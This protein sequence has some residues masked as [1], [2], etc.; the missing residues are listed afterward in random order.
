M[1]IC[2]YLYVVKQY[3]LI[4]VKLETACK[5][6]TFPKGECSMKCS[7]IYVSYQFKN[8]DVIFKGGRLVVLVHDDSLD[9]GLSRRHELRGPRNVELAELHDQR[10]QEA[11]IVLAKI[12]LNN[13]HPDIILI[14]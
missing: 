3:G 6:D 10:R 5:S 13:H 14:I 9:L 4:F 8:G 11:G 1:K 7:I 2:C 12:E